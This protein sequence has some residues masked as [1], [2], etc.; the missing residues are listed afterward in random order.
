MHVWTSDEHTCVHQPLFTIKCSKTKNAMGHL[1]QS[2]AKT[3][4]KRIHIFLYWLLIFF[5]F[6]SSFLSP[7][8]GYIL[9]HFVML[10]R[11]VVQL[12]SFLWSSSGWKKK[13]QVEKENEKPCGKC[14]EAYHMAVLWNFWHRG[15]FQIICTSTAPHIVA[16]KYEEAAKCGNSWIAI[17]TGDW[18]PPS[19]AWFPVIRFLPQTW[20]A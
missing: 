13:T 1:I 16:G 7:A 3:G 18:L 9:F 5:F 11:V 8:V 4:F 2:S 20:T 6:C 17:L 10:P 12:S 15:R 14:S 19:A